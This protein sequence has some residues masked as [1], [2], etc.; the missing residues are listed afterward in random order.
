LQA[1]ALDP[2]EIRPPRLIFCT[3]HQEKA[4]VCYATHG[5]SRVSGRAA[6]ARGVLLLALAALAASSLAATVAAAAAEPC[7]DPADAVVLENKSGVKLVCGC[8]CC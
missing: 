3:L 1:K 2:L 6:R 4:M 7:A 5:P 8:G